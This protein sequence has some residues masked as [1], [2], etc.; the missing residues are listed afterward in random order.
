MLIDPIDGCYYKDSV[1]G[2]WEDRDVGG[3]AE[4]M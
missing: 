1:A 3:G 2:C 4:E